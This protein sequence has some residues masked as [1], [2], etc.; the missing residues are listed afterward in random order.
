MHA[1]GGRSSAVV[2]KVPGM[3]CAPGGMNPLKEDFVSSGETFTA[4]CLSIGCGSRGS[5]FDF[6]SDFDFEKEN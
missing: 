3:E 4:C 5:D 2:E 6:D 1:R